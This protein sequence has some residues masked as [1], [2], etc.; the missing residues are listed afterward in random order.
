MWLFYFRH[1]T[2][3]LI[4]I[5]PIQNDYDGDSDYPSLAHKMI[6]EQFYIMTDWLDLAKEQET[7]NRVIDTIRCLGW[8]VHSI[9]QADNS[10]ISIRFRRSLLDLILSTYFNFSHYTNNIAST[11][12]R[13]WLDRMFLNPKGVDFG[14][15][16]RTNEYL[17]ALKDAWDEFDKVPYQ[18]HEDNGSIP[19]FVTRIFTPLGLNEQSN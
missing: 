19:H 3:L 10:K 14:T 4:E 5:I 18:Y 8:C 12:A 13:Q 2:D 7:D 1:F 11:T 9:C 15:P 17:N 16:E 6:Y